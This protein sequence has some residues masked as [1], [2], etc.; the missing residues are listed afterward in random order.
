MPP[1]PARKPHI[2]P[3]EYLAGER[4]SE[5]RH[6]YIDGQVYAMVGASRPHNLIVNALAVALTPPALLA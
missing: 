1:L 5:W 2:S 4:Q 3:E 6:E